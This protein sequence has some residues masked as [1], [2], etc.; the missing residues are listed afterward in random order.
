MKVAM[1]APSNSPLQMAGLALLWAL[2]AGAAAAAEPIISAQE[3]IDKGALRLPADAV[4]ALLAAGAGIETI[5]PAS[6][7]TRRWTNEPDGNFVASS[8]GKLGTN[9]TAQGTWKVTDSGLYCVEIAWKGGGEQWCRAVY[10]LDSATYLAPADLPKNAD[11]QYGMLTVAGQ[12]G[13][14]AA[15]MASAP[16][17]VA[18]PVAVAAPASTAPSAAAAAK[19]ARSYLDKA[20]VEQTFIGKSMVFKRGNEMVQWELRADGQ[21]FATNRTRGSR[22]AAAWQLADDGKLC[23]KWRGSSQDGCRYYYKEGDKFSITETNQPN[24]AAVAEIQEIQ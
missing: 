11:K 17:S 7:N 10:R 21:L 5:A 18:A 4:K 22:D 1:R 6:G 8:R 14:V 19:G 12:A 16:I 23:V 9:S 24:A 20:Q 13:A 2:G 3:L 15:A